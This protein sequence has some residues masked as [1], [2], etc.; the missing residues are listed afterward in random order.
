M[1]QVIAFHYNYIDTVEANVILM[2]AFPPEICFTGSL[3]CA[4]SWT[5]KTKVAPETV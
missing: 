5:F 4:K 2:F 1:F 3:A